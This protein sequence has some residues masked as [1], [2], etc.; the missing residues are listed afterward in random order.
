MP[1][2]RLSLALPKIAIIVRCSRF[3]I[4]DT[5]TEKLYRTALRARRLLAQ[6]DISYEAALEMVEKYTKHAN[7]KAKEIAKRFGLKS[8]NIDPRGF[9]R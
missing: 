4:V 1:V 8:K 9:L 2:H 7:I 6:G 5:E 3:R